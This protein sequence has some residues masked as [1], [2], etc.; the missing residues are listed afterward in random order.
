MIPS[1]DSLIPYQDKFRDAAHRFGV[2]IRT[3]RRW[4]CHYGIYKSRKGYGPGKL[5]PAKAA[6]I[7]RLYRSD[8]YT[9]SK[10]A[11]QYGV[12]QAMICK[13]IS[14]VAYR[15]DL[16]IGGSVSAK[17]TPA[18]LQVAGVASSAT[19]EWHPPGSTKGKAVDN[20]RSGTR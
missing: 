20:S 18:T 1:K 10:L 8:Q 2:T 15:V 19:N 11:E 16:M 9:Q 12:T 13:I 4:M 6:E 7:R 17:K 5:N 14:N 3:I